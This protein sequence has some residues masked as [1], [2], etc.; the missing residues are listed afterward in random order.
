MINLHFLGVPIQGT[1]VSR[2]LVTDRD[3]TLVHILPMYLRLMD[4]LCVIVIF[5]NTT[6]SI[7]NVHFLCVPIQGTKVSR[8]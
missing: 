3:K 1:K 4:F 8:I 7:I 2:I 5:L 6:N